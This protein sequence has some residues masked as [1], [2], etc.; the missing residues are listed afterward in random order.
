MRFVDEVI[1]SAVEDGARPLVLI[2]ST[3]AARLWPWLTDQ[4]ISPTQIDISDRQW[5]QEDWEGARI[6]RVR[7]DLAPD[8]VEEKWADLVETWEED[9][10]PASILSAEGE[11]GVAVHTSPGGGLF[12]MTH[13]REACATYLSIGRKSLHRNKRGVSCYREVSLPGKRMRKVEGRLVPAEPTRNAAGDTI[14][15]LI[16]HALH[17]DQ[18]PSPN[19]LELVIGMAAPGDEPDVIAEAVERLRYGFGHYREWT[20]QPAPLF[21]ERVIRDYISNF[22]IDDAEEAE[23]EV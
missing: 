10:Q 14:V 13:V 23:D 4:K 2:D 22:A 17:L 3:N 15:G 5:V 21:F 6:V 8:L 9:N 18:W 19:P 11:I 12:R 20:T 16:P 1:S 7:Q